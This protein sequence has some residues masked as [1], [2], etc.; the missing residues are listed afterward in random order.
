[1]QNRGIGRAICQSILSRPDLPS[2][3]LFATSRK[4]EDLGLSATANNGNILYSRL[5]ISSPDSIHAF[6]DEVKK[7]GDVNVL[8]NN[9]GINLDAKYGPET[10]R[11]TLDVN[12]RGT[13]K[14]CRKSHLRVDLELAV[15]G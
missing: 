7:H 1:M 8:I 9:A 14:V 11:E 4:G 3:K 10:V 12:Y 5:D 15:E 13:V 6:G 2:L